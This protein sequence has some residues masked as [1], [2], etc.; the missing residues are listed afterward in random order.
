MSQQRK[1]FLLILL[2]L[3]SKQHRL[4]KMLMRNDELQG[5]ADEKKLK[6]LMINQLLFLL[7]NRDAFWQKVGLWLTHLLTTLYYFYPSQQKNHHCCHHGIYAISLQLLA[8]RYQWVV[9]LKEEVRR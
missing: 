1:L 2:L 5:V 6:L 7:Q 9:V 3:I 4:K 8:K